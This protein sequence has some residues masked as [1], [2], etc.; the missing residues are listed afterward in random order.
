MNKII[1]TREQLVGISNWAN[2]NKRK[3]EDTFYP[4]L[5]EGQLECYDWFVAEFEITLDS[6]R[7]IIHFNI[8]YKIWSTRL[9]VVVEEVGFTIKD[10]YY[11]L[12]D[13][14]LDNTKLDMELF[15]EEKE[16]TVKEG[17]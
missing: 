9:D 13:N 15:Y 16:K 2:S 6:D 3:I 10:G 11:S 7:P 1:I 4:Y 14:R 12:P 5:L 8:D 17:I